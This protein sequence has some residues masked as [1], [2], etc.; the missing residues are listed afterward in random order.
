[1]L[2]DELSLVANRSDARGVRGR[3][4][5][6]AGALIQSSSL[7]S[8]M[9]VTRTAATAHENMNQFDSCSGP[10]SLPPHALVPVFGNVITD[11]D[12]FLVRYS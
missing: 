12:W 10:P 5:P 4:G 7:G 9:N 2:H 6:E 11:I 8:G 3:S 1:M